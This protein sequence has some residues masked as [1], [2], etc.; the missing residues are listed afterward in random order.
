MGVSKE[1]DLLLG[2]INE[3]NKINQAE[4]KYSKNLM[5]FS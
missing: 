1:V 2:E 4:P 3:K 5:K